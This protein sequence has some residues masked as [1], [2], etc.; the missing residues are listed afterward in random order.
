MNPKI[1]FSQLRQELETRGW[2]AESIETNNFGVNRRSTVFQN[3]DSD[4]YIILPRTRPTK[5]VEPIHLLH[6]RNVLENAGFWDSLVRQTG[7]EDRGEAS[8]VLQTLAE[9]KPAR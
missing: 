5:T 7:A 1:T 2:K 3:P 6:V 4:L 9:I 8:R